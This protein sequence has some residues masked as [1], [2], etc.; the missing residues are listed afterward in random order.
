MIPTNPSD[1]H[2]AAANPVAAVRP[3]PWV[4]E[5]DQ[6]DRNVALVRCA[7]W[8]LRDHADDLG[9]SN[10]HTAPIGELAAA[11]DAAVE[12]CEYTPAFTAGELAAITAAL[13]GYVSLLR[14]VSGY[15]TVDD[16]ERL[17]RKAARLRDA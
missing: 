14:T 5:L 1:Q 3:V 15:A 2:P 7:L 11:L 10:A 16:L 12:G 9:V 17:A 13:E 6:D 8:R 4:P